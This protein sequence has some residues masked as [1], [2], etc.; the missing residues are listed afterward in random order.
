MNQ[1]AASASG[2]LTSE[3]NRSDIA[4]LGSSTD[5]LFVSCTSCST[6]TGN[7]VAVQ[8]NCGHVVT[9]ARFADSLIQNWGDSLAENAVWYQTS[10]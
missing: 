3:L 2:A 8:A 1:P 6:I 4:A 7:W 10:A 5:T 9:V